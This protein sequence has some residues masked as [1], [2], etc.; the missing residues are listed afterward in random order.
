MSPLSSAPTACTLYPAPYCFLF[1]PTPS[2]MKTSENLR[3][4]THRHHRHGFIFSDSLH[5]TPEW[6]ADFELLFKNAKDRFPDVVWAPNAED[7]DPEGLKEEVWGHKAI[8]YAR[9][10][11]LF[12]NRYFKRSGPHATT[13]PLPY[14]VPSEPAF[15]LDQSLL[16]HRTPSPSQLHHQHLIDDD[17]DG[18]DEPDTTVVRRSPTSVPNVQLGPTSL[19]RLTTNINAALFADEL[20]YLYMGRSFGEAFN[21]LFENT[22]S[23]S[24]TRGGGSQEEQDTQRIDKLRKD[25]VFMWRSRLYAD[26]RIAL[27]GNFSSL[28]GT[29]DKENT[30]AIFSSHRFLL[31]SRSSYFQTALQTWN[32]PQKPL[33]SSGALALTASQSTA[34]SSFSHLPIAPATPEAPLHTLPSPPFTPASLHFTLGFLYTGTLVFSH[35]SYNLSTALALLSSS[36]YL[37]LTTLFHEAQAL[38]VQEMLHG[39]FHVFLPFAEYEMVAAGRWAAAGCRCRQCAWRVPRVLAFAL[40]PEGENPLLERG[41]RQALVGLFG[42]GWCTAEFARILSP[43][44]REVAVQGVGK[45]TTVR[46][47][48]NLLWA[49]EWGLEKVREA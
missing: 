2:G 20:E 12:Q 39:L 36:A 37:G 33:T 24:A 19:L 30:T 29:G 47:V 22:A 5:A 23:T 28:H 8:V 49:A 31:V 45:R 9:A 41:A 27:T 40:S 6:E 34:D 25:L 21:F 17:D 48:F 15:S 16:P 10:P 35:R 44:M 1:I 32:A 43:K 3:T 11:P 26:V 38:L 18:D 4:R 46:N 13:S 42:E 7:D 14:A